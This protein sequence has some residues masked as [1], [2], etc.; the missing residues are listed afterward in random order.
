MQF[1]YI[2]EMFKWFDTNI[3][4]KSFYCVNNQ[5]NFSHTISKVLKTICYPRV[6]I[7]LFIFYVLRRMAEMK[8][9]QTT[10]VKQHMENLVGFFPPTTR[11]Q[12]KMK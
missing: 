10:I 1:R 8:K 5:N 3:S 2:F 4:W 6:I 11:D 7:F 12:Y 9:E